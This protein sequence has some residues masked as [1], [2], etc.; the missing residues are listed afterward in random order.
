MLGTF[1]LT[2]ISFLLFIGIYILVLINAH[3]KRPEKY[4]K[5]FEIKIA[6]ENTRF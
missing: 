4:Y 3:Y 6:V 2:Y 1:M 5:K